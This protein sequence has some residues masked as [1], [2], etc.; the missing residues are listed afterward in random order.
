MGLSR[1]NGFCVKQFFDVLAVR[2]SHGA[3]YLLIGG[4]AVNYWAER[5]LEEETEL[6]EFL[7]FTSEDIDFKGTRMDVQLIA[8]QLGCKALFPAKVEISSL[9]GVIPIHIGE[10]ESN[11]EVIRHVP[12]VSANDLEKLAIEAEFEGKRIRVI[13]PI[14]LLASK[15][16]LAFTI[17][18]AKRQDVAHLRILIHCVHGFLRDLLTLVENAEMP[19]AGW[20]GAVNHLHKL[21]GSKHGKRAMK[22]HGI[23]WSRL[24]PVAEISAASNAKIVRFREMQLLHWQKASGDEVAG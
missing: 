8:G 22:Q 24:L 9:A 18:Q 6:R 12:G 21:A 17:S 16:K 10:V 13:N 20:L 5:Y 11:I 7:P 15:L 2:N 14:S 19:A 23:D 4:Q 1:R 3:P